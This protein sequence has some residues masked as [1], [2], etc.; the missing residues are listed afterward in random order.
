MSSYNP[1]FDPHPPTKAQEAL[2]QQIEQ[3]NQSARENNQAKLNEKVVSGKL[4]R[5]CPLDQSPLNA[6]KSK[7]VEDLNLSMPRYRCVLCKS[8]FQ[9]YGLNLYHETKK[10]L[11]A[12]VF[13]LSEVI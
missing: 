4:M 9:G 5:Y 13:P 6:I 10:S 11:M 8:V 2:Q 3:L 1:Y 7:P 12:I